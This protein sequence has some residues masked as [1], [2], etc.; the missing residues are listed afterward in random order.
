MVEGRGAQYIAMLVVSKTIIIYVTFITDNTV[1]LLSYPYSLL[2][3]SLEG[4]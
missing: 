4:S 3:E 2:L 1:T